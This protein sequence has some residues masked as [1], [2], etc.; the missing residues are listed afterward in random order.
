M[1]LICP[2]CRGELRPSSGNTAVCIHHGGRFE[3]LFDRFA[4]PAAAD[5]PAEVAAAPTAAPAAA[6]HVHPKQAAVASCQACG[7]AFCSLCTFDVNGQAFC[8]DCAIA[9]TAKP[10]QKLCPDCD[11]SVPNSIKKC[12]CGHDFTLLNLNAPRRRNVPTGT[13]AHHP[14]VPGVVRC[15]LCSKSICATCDFALPGGVH[16]CPS[17]IENESSGEISP[18]RK[19][20]TYIA[21][22]LATWS[23]LLIGFLLT[24][25]FNTLFTHDASGKLADMAITNLILWPLLVGTGLSIGALDRKLRNTG[26]MKA[27][28]WWNGVLVAISLLFVIGAN[29]GLIGK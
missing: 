3:V 24:G 21:I 20:Q 11:P 19:K 23:T 25:A 10:G 27:A 17:C 12:D 1:D 14:E 7:T 6:C 22:G 18:K 26:L 28:A 4:E 16:L 29:V 8:G 5:T 2:D 15:K 13:C 9:L